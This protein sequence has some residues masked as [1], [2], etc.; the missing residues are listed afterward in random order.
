MLSRAGIKPA[1]TQSLLRKGHIFVKQVVH[2]LR[3]RDV[4]V[5]DV[6]PPCCQPNGLLVSTVASFISN[7]TERE[8]LKR[9]GAGLIRQAVERP[10]LIRMVMR[11]VRSTG[12]AQVAATLRSRMDIPSPLGYSSAGTVMEIGA[13]AQGFSVGDRVACAGAGFAAHAAVNW[14]PQNLCVKIPGQVS[15]EEAASV[16]LG[17][18]ALQGV[19]I[20]G[21]SVGERVAVIGLGLAGLLTGQI[22]KAAGCWVIGVDPDLDRVLLA[23]ELGFD[24]A[25]SSLA[26]RDREPLGNSPG[27]DAVILTAA[28]P[29]RRP[30][31]LAGELARDRG[32]VVVVGDVRVDVPRELYYKKELQIRYSR[33]YGPGRYDP[34]YEEQGRDYPRGYVRWT[35]KRNM[36]AYL[37]LVASGKIRVLPMITHRFPVERARQAYD[38][39]AGRTPERPVGIVLN[40]PHVAPLERKC[41]VRAQ[42][43]MKPNRAQKERELRIGWIGAGNFS[44]SILLPALR[45]I[46]GIKLVGVANASGISANAAARRFGFEYCATEA[47]QVLSDPGI[48]IVFIA[49]R[50]HLHATMVAAG[51][52]RGKHVFVEKPLCVNEEE[53]L[54]IQSACQDSSRLLAVGFNRRFSRA[55]RESARFLEGQRGP[56]SILY[57]VNVPTLPPGHWGL[58]AEQGHGRIVGEVCHFVDF[59]QFLTQALPVRVQAWPM[60]Q[61]TG[62]VEDNFEARIE[63]EDGSSAHLSYLSTGASTLA[64]ERIEL[65]GDGRTVV[66]DDFKKCV[67]LDSHRTR[68]LRLIRQDKGHE[69][70]LRAFI[71][72]IRQGAPS[73]ISFASL[74]A[75]TRATLKIRESLRTGEPRLVLE[76]ERSSSY[77]ADRAQARDDFGISRDGSDCDPVVGRK[78]EEQ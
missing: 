46:E 18:I 40:Y 25:Y 61:S 55:A 66:V 45:R 12:L 74:A 47:E 4:Q 53:I 68:T 39:V 43:R 13:G 57:R 23:R 6:P 71:Q 7:G 1:P 44:R 16:A 36:D 11:R 75:T 48:D 34:A 8:M 76:A 27:C 70:E 50:H 60:P 19:R 3:S 73:P 64:K 59:I 2:S 15:F 49:T 52:E 65:H 41:Q 20:A 67:F 21:A 63:M 33:S 38:L 14:V 69:A 51:L 10:E 58:D 78:L 35:E 31:E 54:Q 24:E 42:D 26:V 22:L 77:F 72:A 32:I 5:E 17:A 30:V 29:S 9:G 56:L 28:T 62:S 37:D